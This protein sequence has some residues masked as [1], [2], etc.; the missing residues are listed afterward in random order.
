MLFQ[1]SNLTRNGIALQ[2]IY[3]AKTHGFKKQSVHGDASAHVLLLEQSGNGSA[4]S[5][6]RT[7]LPY[8]KGGQ[9]NDEA[10][11]TSRPPRRL[12]AAMVQE[13]KVRATQRL[14][15]GGQAQRREP[16]I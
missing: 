11:Q 7:R 5:S 13:A 14:G 10:H 1:A 12:C 9:K 6:P 3:A 15:K 2:I 16:Q 8:P 4:K